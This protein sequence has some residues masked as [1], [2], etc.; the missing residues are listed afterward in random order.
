R[1][2]KLRG[3]AASLGAKSVFF[4]AGQLEAAYLTVDLELATHLR[5]RLAE[6]LCRLRDAASPVLEKARPLAGAGMID[7]AAAGTDACA[8]RGGPGR[9]RDLE[10]LAELLRR[11]DLAALALSRSVS[12]ELERLLGVD[13]YRRMVEHIENLRF[14]QASRDLSAVLG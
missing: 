10:R 4:I 12:I 1:M 2:H 14:E 13:P 5:A 6:S 11:Q 7:A 9:P 3:A 8:G